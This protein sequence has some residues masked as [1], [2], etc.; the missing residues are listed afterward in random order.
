MMAILQVMMAILK[1]FGIT[2]GILVWV[3]IILDSLENEMD[4]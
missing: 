2:G 3:L 4:L 1:F